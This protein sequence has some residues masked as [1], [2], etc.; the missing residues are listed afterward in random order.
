[1]LHFEFPVQRPAQQLC[2]IV[3][4]SPH[5]SG[6]SML[7]VWLWI[8]YH[9]SQSGLQWLNLNPFIYVIISSLSGQIIM[10]IDPV[11]GTGFLTPWIIITF[12]MVCTTICMMPSPSAQAPP[13]YS[14]TGGFLYPLRI[15][16]SGFIP[17]IWLFW[18]N[19]V[20]KY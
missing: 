1:M 13:L 18:Y 17:I 8:I 4:N 14:H 6:D 3:P 10:R 11:L 2:S 5:R 12:S 16:S 7:S 15:S 19:R 20:T 9:S